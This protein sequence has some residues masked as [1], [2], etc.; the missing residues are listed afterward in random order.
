MHPPACSTEHGINAKNY[1]DE[2]SLMAPARNV[3]DHMHRVGNIGSW[4]LRSGNS[5]DVTVEGDPDER[6]LISCAWDSPTPFSPVDSWYYETVVRPRVVRRVMAYVGK[7]SAG[8]VIVTGG[9]R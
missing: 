9:G 8:V 5:C 6:V 3:E 2:S 4:T 1:H 7:P